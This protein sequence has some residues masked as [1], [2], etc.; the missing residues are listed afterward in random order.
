MHNSISVCSSAFIGYAQFFITQ[1]N[2]QENERAATAVE[3]K[4]KELSAKLRKVEEERAAKKSARAQAQKRV[5]GARRRLEEIRAKEGFKEK[6]VSD[7]NGMHCT[8]RHIFC[9]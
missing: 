7:I 5:E 3:K 4:F 8:C 6:V 2:L 1:R 9:N